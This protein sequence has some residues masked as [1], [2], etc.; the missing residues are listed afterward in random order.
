MATAFDRDARASS[1]EMKK[2][3]EDMKAAIKRLDKTQKHPF[4]HETKFPDSPSE[5]SAALFNYAY[6]NEPLVSVH[7]L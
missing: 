4:P 3:F 6:P 5:L 7:A 2:A 1:A